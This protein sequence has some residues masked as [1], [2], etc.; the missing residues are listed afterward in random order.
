MDSKREKSGWIFWFG[1]WLVCSFAFI[2]LCYCMLNLRAGKKVCT[3]S[4]WIPRGCFLLF[5]LF[6]YFIDESVFY[7]KQGRIVKCDPQRN[8][9]WSSVIVRSKYVLPLST[10]LCSKTDLNQSNYF[11]K[12][13][14]RIQN[15]HDDV[16]STRR[17]NN[18]EPNELFPKLMTQFSFMNELEGNLPPNRT[19]LMFLD[20]LIFIL[21]MDPLPR[22]YF[23]KLLFSFAYWFLITNTTQKKQ[24]KCQRSS[25]SLSFHSRSE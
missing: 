17:S 13:T 8:T 3:I 21:S 1:W 25:T 23:G 2:L 24:N 18:G 16:R 5:L 19:T 12:M 4:W 7:L 20:F 15:D 10:R 11:I 22:G 6:L 14:H 9:T